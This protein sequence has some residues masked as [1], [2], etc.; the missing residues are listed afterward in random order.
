MASGGVLAPGNNGLGALTT[1]SLSLIGASSF[2]LQLNATAGT[3]GVNWDKVAASTLDIS[4][5][6]AS[7]HKFTLTLQTLDAGNNPGALA[8]GWDGSVNHTWAGV[9]TFSSLSGT[10]DPN[11]FTIDTS[12][13]VGYSISQGSFAVAQNGNQLDVTYLAAVPEPGTWAML[14][15]GMGMLVLFQRRRSL[16]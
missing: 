12:N 16:Q 6:D 11:M 2:T 8:G 4:A 13:F 15:G 9:I 5:L 10:F 14:L 1:G 7:T 3:S